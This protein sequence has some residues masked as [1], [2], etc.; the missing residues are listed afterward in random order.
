[1]RSNCPI[2]RH[3]IHKGSVNDIK[4]MDGKNY[5]ATCSADGS[6]K[7]LNL[8]DFDTVLDIKAGEMVFSLESS[9]DVVLAGS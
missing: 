4:L 3:M 6:I 7:I 5:F 9:E 8:P 1:M 2:Y